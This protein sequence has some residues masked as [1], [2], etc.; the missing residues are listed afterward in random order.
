MLTQLDTR[1]RFERRIMF[2]FGAT[3]LLLG[4][5]AIHVL[6]LQW[7]EHHKLAQQADRNRI[8]VL[9]VLPV[10]GEIVDSKGRELAINKIA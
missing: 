1:R 9:P 6:H 5:L 4:V 7:I 3:A 8:N 10:R 2:F